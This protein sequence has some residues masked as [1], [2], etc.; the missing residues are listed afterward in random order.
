MARKSYTASAPNCTGS[1]TLNGRSKSERI[2]HQRRD[3]AQLEVITTVI[4]ILVFSEYDYYAYVSELSA[5]RIRR[6][7]A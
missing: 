1:A 3:R 6:G 4:V 7:S 5:F 2:G